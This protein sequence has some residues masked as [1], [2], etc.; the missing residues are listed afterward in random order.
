MRPTGR[1]SLERLG[2]GVDQ[3]NRQDGESRV[4]CG[5]GSKAKGET[6]L[7]SVKVK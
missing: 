3:G 2:D 7:S 4:V 1:P 5:Q 6:F